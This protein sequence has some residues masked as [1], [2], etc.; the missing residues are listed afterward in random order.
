MFGLG[1]DL[2]G[3]VGRVR[4]RICVGW[5]RCCEGRVRT[6][7]CVG[8]VRC[9][10]GRVRTRVCGRKV[11][12]IVLR[13]VIADSLFFVGR[14]FARTFESEDGCRCRACIEKCVIYG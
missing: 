5:V 3:V 11:A 9:C 8:W 13:F 1:S 2:C 10:V 6:R 4:T 12:S 7:I 14:V